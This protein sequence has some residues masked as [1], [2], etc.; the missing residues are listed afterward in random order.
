MEHLNKLLKKMNLDEVRLILA[1]M[2]IGIHTF[3]FTCISESFDYL[4]TRVI[5]RIAVPIYLMITGYYIINKS[6][7]DK[8]ILLKYLKNIFT[9]YLFSIIIYGIFLIKKMPNVLEI[10]KSILFTG[11]LYHL[12]Y[13][14]ALILGVIIA[15]LIVKYIPKKYQGVV[16]IVL[17]FIGILGDNYFGFIENISILNIFYNTIIN[18]TGYT[19]NFLFYVPIFLLLGYK[20]SIEEEPIDNKENIL[21]ISSFT[22]LL[23]IEGL[24]I[25]TIGKPLHTSMYI[26]LP[27]LTYFIFKYLITNLNKEENKKLR[28]LSSYIY[29][30]HP[31][32]IIILTKLR[33]IKFIDNSLIFYLLVSL[34]TYFSCK[35]FL[36]IREKCVIKQLT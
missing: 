36:K 24:I 20:I 35:V 9:I 18:I 19:R 3:P 34:I 15:Y 33:F 21:Y 28:K 22:I 13:F 1:F 12:W 16:S 4:I 8:K 6:L 11:P 2:I 17:Y 10:L 29:I 32:I 31:W 14:P 7:K 27:F 23:I 26:S 25:R 30:M 5:F